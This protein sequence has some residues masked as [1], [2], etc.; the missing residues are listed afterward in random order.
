MHPT[1][2]PWISLTLALVA[3]SPALAQLGF[4]A[5]EPSSPRASRET[6]E[7]AEA[8]TA[9][10]LEVV[11]ESGQIRR[12]LRPEADTFPMR[13]GPVAPYAP[14]GFCYGKSRA[15]AVWFRHI[16][17]GGYNAT[18]ENPVYT[19]A[20]EAVHRGN[21]RE[22]RMRARAMRRSQA[23]GPPYGL[24]VLRS[25][26]RQQQLS[27]RMV[28]EVRRDPRQNTPDASW[29]VQQWKREIYRWGSSGLGYSYVTGSGRGQRHAVLLVS[30]ERCTVRDS[31]GE[32]PATRFR[33]VDPGAIEGEDDTSD[34]YLYFLEDEKKL[35]FS[36]TY[37]ER[38]RNYPDRW[39]LQTALDGGRILHH[40]EVSY[41][42]VFLEDTPYAHLR[43][44][45]SAD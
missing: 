8:V 15:E 42:D 45:E 7:Q 3:S 24:A 12:G 18:E 5:P 33:V 9:H 36:P 32:H 25:F 14:D 40:L 34:S 2:S 17:R 44:G 41:L 23:E 16:V 22:F 20:G 21:F 29:K 38:V 4:D 37:V 26:A 27:P 30:Y 35:T 10:S 28:E 19:P 11:S 6:I 1:R 13:N 43:T 31:R 39:L